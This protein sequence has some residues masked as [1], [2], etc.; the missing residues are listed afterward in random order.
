[1]RRHGAKELNYS[2]FEL[3]SGDIKDQWSA[4]INAANVEAVI[5]FA[6]SAVSRIKPIVTPPMKITAKDVAYA[7]ACAPPM[8]SK[9]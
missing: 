8:L 7:L 2:S 9:W 6:R 5:F 1:M 4:K 3:E